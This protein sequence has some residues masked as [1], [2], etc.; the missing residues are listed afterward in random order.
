MHEKAFRSKFTNRSSYK[1]IEFLENR[2]ER[3]KNEIKT[4]QKKKF[5]QKIAVL[6]D[7]KNK[8]QNRLD[9][10]NQKL[11]NIQQK[12]RDIKKYGDI[13]PFDFNDTNQQDDEINLNEFIDLAESNKTKY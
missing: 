2:L 8:I 9:L 5:D 11:S 13:N 6:E 12:N 1:K 10:E 3:V 7:S 4:N